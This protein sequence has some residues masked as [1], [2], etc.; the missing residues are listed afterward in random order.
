[1]HV[2]PGYAP[3]IRMHMQAPRP[4]V[5]NMV[6]TCAFNPSVQRWKIGYTKFD[7]KVPVAFPDGNV[8]GF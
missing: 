6:T 7:I 4:S 8:Y 3:R 1:M 5:A 2:L